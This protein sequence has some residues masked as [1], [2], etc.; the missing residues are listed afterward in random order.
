MSEEILPPHDDGQS[1]VPAAPSDGKLPAGEEKAVVPNVVAV[2]A[3]GPAPKRT[4]GDFVRDLFRTRLDKSAGRIRFVALAFTALY[5]VVGVRLAVL[6][7]RHD[8][9]ETF[10]HVA[11]EAAA[12][13]RPDILDRNGEIMATDVKVTSIFAEPKRLID[14]DEAADQLTSVL[15]GVDVKE[16][17]ERL[18]SHKGFVWV[19]RDVTPAEQDAVFHL[20]LPGV[21]FLPEDKRIYPNG[22][23]AAHVLGFTNIDN[24][25]IAGIEKYIDNQGLADLH[26][27]GF[28][29]PSND[30]KPLRLSIDMKVSY[31]LRDEL[32]QGL[33][34]YKAKAAGGAILDVNTGEVIAFASLPDYDPNTPADALDPNRI[35][36]MTVGVYEMGS[37]FKAMTLA[38]GLDEGKITLNSKL[39]ARGPLHFGRFTIHDDEPKGRALSVPEVFTFSSNIGAARIA[40]MVGV[41]GHKAFL[42]KMG[43]LERMRTELPE[44]A[45]PIVPKNWSMLNTITIAFGHGVAVA[46]LQAAM[47][48]AAIVNGGILVR[49]T[50]LTRTAEEAQ[51]GAPRII[52]PET[53][54]E[55]RYLLRLNAEIGTAKMAN[56]PG[57]FVGGKTGTAEKVIGGRYNK[58]RLFTTFMAI[59]P[60]DKPKYLFLTIY[61][62]PQ[63]LKETFGFATAAWNSGAVTGKVIERVG[64]LL[65]LA[66][67]INLPEMPFPVVARLGIGITR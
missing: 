23:V 63:G 38:M 45:M 12:A 1:P 15:P 60:A 67:R 57:Y 47:A 61:D 36:R 4:W 59:V 24:A 16:L 27:A 41:D 9:P 11:A 58:H 8:P 20:G 34:K 14:R 17:R 52:S 50:F 33:I 56:I 10:K 55:M 30:L 7:M 3:P 26:G 42:R 40:M 6:G 35:N 51:D 18:N 39:D 32:Q 5:G 21:G 13:A 65:G 22:P 62:E 37:T 64:P 54:E 53:S 2:E 29:L 25:G 31:A 19:K 46:P 44:S 49:P 66:P 48:V 28:N 43:Q